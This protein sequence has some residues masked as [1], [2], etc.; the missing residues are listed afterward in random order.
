MCCL[1]TLTIQG[2]SGGSGDYLQVPE[3]QI[4]ITEDEL[5]DLIADSERPYVIVNFFATWCKPCAQ[6]L[7]ELVA[8]QNAADSKVEVILI[9]IDSE[10]DAESKLREFLADFGV[11]FQTYAQVN[12][13]GAFVAQFYT[14]WDNRIPLSLIFTR[15]GKLVEAITGIT[16][17]AEIELIVNM[18]QKLGS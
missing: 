18:H 17:R 16:D 2:C 3:P 1:L 9:S 8:L 7:P 4:G 13:P 14:L 10:E 6:E 15:E 12:H 5:G 11:D